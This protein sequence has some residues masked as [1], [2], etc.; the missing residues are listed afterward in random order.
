MV[1]M[2]LGVA[3]IRAPLGVYAVYAVCFVAWIVGAIVVIVTREK[4]FQFSS[5]GPEKI[6]FQSLFYK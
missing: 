6:D 4:T 3:E 5:H 2:L 1:Q